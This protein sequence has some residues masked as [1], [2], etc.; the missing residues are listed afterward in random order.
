[1]S[2]EDKAELLTLRPELAPR[3]TQTHG[4]GSWGTSSSEVKGAQQSSP[5]WLGFLHN[6]WGGRAIYLLSI[7]SSALLTSKRLVL[8]GEHLSGTS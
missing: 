3:A 6:T 7:P 1:M 5:V 4:F 8:V 2:S